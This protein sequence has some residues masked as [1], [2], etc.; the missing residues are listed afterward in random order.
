MRRVGHCHIHV[1]E[2]V[3]DADNKDPGVVGEDGC[4]ISFSDKGLPVAV[5]TSVGEMLELRVHP[6]LDAQ[7]RGAFFVEALAS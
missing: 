3:P 2:L 6:N 4:Y 7:D 1:N 5:V